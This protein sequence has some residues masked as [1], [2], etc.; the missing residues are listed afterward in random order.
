MDEFILSQVGT[1]L[2]EGQDIDLGLESSPIDVVQYP[3]TS[4]R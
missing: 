4:F 2:S 1:G 3:I